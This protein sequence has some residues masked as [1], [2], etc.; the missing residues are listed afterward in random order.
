MLKFG[1]R[2]DDTEDL[3]ASD[4]D[5]ASTAPETDAE[6]GKS[7]VVSSTPEKTPVDDTESRETGVSVHSG[8]RKKLS[9]IQDGDTD[10]MEASRILEECRCRMGLSPAEVEEITKIR[11]VYINA[12]EQGNFD[13]LPQ[14][15]Y[16]L[17]Y[18][19][20][21][22]EL[23]DMT[24]QEIEQVVTP[25][26]ELQFESPENYPAAVYSDESGDNRTVIRRLEAVIFSI[27][28]L[29]VVALIIFGVVLLISLLRGN[30]DSD[31]VVF[32]EAGIVQLQES[33]QLKVSEP[34]PL[35]RR[36]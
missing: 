22:C 5:F 2:S 7:E 35:S 32:D 25:W 9:R 18:I 14:A 34:L 17:A 33:P 20:R 23:Y 26:N 12:L 19:R 27:I 13:E 6:A 4:D 15:V 11:A 21:L 36:R 24:P 1:K 31:G 29:A 30:A 10:K 3:F 16:T 28:A 8:S